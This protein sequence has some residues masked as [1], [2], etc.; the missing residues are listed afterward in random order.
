MIFARVVAATVFLAWPAF[1]KP[2]SSQMTV[3]DLQILCEGSNVGEACRF[4]I[5]GVVEG[6]AL[7]AGVAKDKAHFCVPDGLSNAAMVSVIKNFVARDLKAYPADS[8]LPAVSFI[9]AGVMR[10]YPCAL[11]R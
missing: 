9:A 4:Y 10:A 8:G 1:A 3:G 11:A 6:S 2:E 5:L 7:A